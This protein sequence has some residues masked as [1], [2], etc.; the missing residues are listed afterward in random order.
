LA[1]SLRRQ[2]P[3]AA[4]LLQLL[5]NL[6]IFDNSRGGLQISS[7]CESVIRSAFLLDVVVLQV[8]LS[9]AGRAWGHDLTRGLTRPPAPLP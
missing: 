2:R 7:Y 5:F 9:E 1:R 8:R 6:I 3:S 4:N